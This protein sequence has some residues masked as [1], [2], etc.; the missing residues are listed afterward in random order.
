MHYVHL[1][2]LLHG[3]V[4]LIGAEGATTPETFRQNE[5][6]EYKKNG[7]TLPFP[8]FKQMMLD[9]A[10]LEFSKQINKRVKDK[11]K[12]EGLS[13]EFTAQKL[14]EGKFL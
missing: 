6:Y 12:D 14:K 4:Q 10:D 8:Q 7:G 5:Y 3:R 2:V 9:E 1:T 13:F 11:M